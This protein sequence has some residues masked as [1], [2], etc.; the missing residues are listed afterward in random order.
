[1]LKQYSI[2][3]RITLFAFFG[4]LLF[5]LQSCKEESQIEVLPDLIALDAAYTKNPSKMATLDMDQDKFMNLV[6]STVKLTPLDDVMPDEAEVS[7][8]TRLYLNEKGKVDKLLFLHTVPQVF[9]PS[10]FVPV[11][12][13][14]S[15]APATND[16]KDVKSQLLF[17]ITGT[18]DFENQQWSYEI[19]VKNKEHMVSNVDENDYFV[20]VEEMPEP[21][22]GIHDIQKNIVYP[23]IAK[24]AG[25]EGKVYVLALINEEGIV[26]NAKIIK[27]IGG[28]CDEVAL[29]AIKDAK[30]T[31]GRQRGKRVKVKV[32]IPVVFKLQ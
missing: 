17:I 6:N 1:M 14:L 20:A 11:F 3:F 25:I 27:G 19:P 16:G 2:I 15:F 22:G 7:V 30:F 29:N 18:W 31:P 9:A 10:I 5:S 28:G 32:T 4:I 21:I 12:E 23:E 13:K 8:E 26:D 24:R